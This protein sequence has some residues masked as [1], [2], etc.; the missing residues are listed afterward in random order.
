[1]GLFLDGATDPALPPG[2]YFFTPSQVTQ[3]GGLYALERRAV[4]TRS[5]ER[6][7]VERLVIPF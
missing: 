3:P 6:Q 1:M 7:S 2:Q 5:G 4:E